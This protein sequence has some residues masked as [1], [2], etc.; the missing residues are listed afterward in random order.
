MSEMCVRAFLAF[1]SA[2]DTAEPV[3]TETAVR[4]G[5]SVCCTL[6]RGS[7]SL[8]FCRSSFRARRA[9]SPQRFTTAWRQQIASL[10]CHR[11]SRS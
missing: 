2:T 8:Q 9:S 10:Q 11:R 3:C 1:G 4:G 7:R 6:A 5:H